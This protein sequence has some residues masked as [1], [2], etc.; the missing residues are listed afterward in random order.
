MRL[1]TGR[2]YRFERFMSLGRIAFMTVYI[3]DELRTVRKGSNMYLN[4]LALIVYAGFQQGAPSSFEL[5]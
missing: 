2:D 1:R 4:R 5:T 3:V